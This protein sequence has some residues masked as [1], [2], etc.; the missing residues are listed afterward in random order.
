MRHHPSFSTRRALTALVGV[1]ALLA[2]SAPAASATV[3]KVTITANTIKAFDLFD[4]SDGRNVPVNMR[5][6]SGTVDSAAAAGDTVTVGCFNP[7]TGGLSTTFGTATVTSAKKWSVTGSLYPINGNYCRIVAVPSGTTSVTALGLSSLYKGSKIASIYSFG[8]SYAGLGG[9]PHTV[10]TYDYEFDTTSKTLNYGNT[11]SIGSCGLCTA[12]LRDQATDA[13]GSSLWGWNS[14]NYDGYSD[15]PTA[16]TSGPNAD[17]LMLVDGK[18]AMDVYMLYRRTSAGD[19]GVAFGAAG[20]ITLGYSVNQANG[21]LT[22]TESQPL[23]RC[24]DVT[25][26]SQ[27]RSCTVAAPTGVRMNRT[28]T[29]TADGAIWRSAD[30]YASADG[31]AHTVRA[32]YVNY[33]YGN[34]GYRYGTSGAYAAKTKG[35]KTGNALGSAG[36]PYVVLGVKYDQSNATVDVNNPVGDIVMTPRPA[37]VRVVADNSK[38]VYPRWSLSVPK[39]G[40]SPVVK[41]A[42]T[43]AAS[44][45]NLVK[46]RN[47][48]IAGLAK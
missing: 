42:Y 38:Y 26:P 8:R 11:Y 16:P 47:A 30:A 6:V 4:Y 29:V 22:V 27:W 23:Y 44:D 18:L 10:F 20:G 48:A 28:I 33:E 37:M 5:T 46:L 15:F 24:V 45:A 43:I 21:D 7:I 31:K 36:K 19:S 34:L 1:S 32:T 12:R 40:S 41:Q 39:G 14:S 35:D 9:N 3:T 25:D 17:P 13:R 2:V